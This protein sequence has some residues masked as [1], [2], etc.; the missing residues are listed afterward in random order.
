MRMLLLCVY[1]CCVLCVCVRV[2]ACARACVSACVHACMSVCVHLGLRVYVCMWVEWRGQQGPSWGAQLAR[3]R[4]RQGSMASCHTL[5][6][7]M[8][9][10][11]SIV[12]WI[13]PN[14]LNG[15]GV[16]RRRRRR[17]RRRRCV[18]V[19]M[20]KAFCKVQDCLQHKLH[21]I[22]F[23]PHTHMV[24][25]C[26]VHHYN[27]DGKDAQLLVSIGHVTVSQSDPVKT[28]L[29]NALYT[30]L[31]LVSLHSSWAVSQT[32]SHG[33]ISNI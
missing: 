29:C 17:R 13:L 25:S 2:C 28:Q 8:T 32:H 33:R 19:H 20:C 3:D 10:C 21:F 31:H 1:V 6:S 30:N 16:K 7:N 11:T 18:C 4:E 14:V 5:N 22:H 27:R 24:L 12:F 23:V 15:Q 26:K 9:L